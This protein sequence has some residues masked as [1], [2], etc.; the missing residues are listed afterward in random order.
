MSRFPKIG[1]LPIGLL[2][3]WLIGLCMQLLHPADQP[4]YFPPD[5][6]VE[7]YAAGNLNAR[8]QNPY[9][10]EL[11]LPIER[12]A[13]RVTDEAI[14]MW[15]P[16]W[17][18]A[19]AMP[20]G[21]LQPRPAHTSWIISGVLLILFSAILSWRL[22]KGPVD[23]P[24]Y[25]TMLAIT[26]LPSIFV[27]QAGQIGTFLL[28]G[29]VALWYGVQHRQ[30]WI[31]GGGAALLAIKPH[32]V[33][34]LWPALLVWLVTERS[35]FVVLSAIWCI[36][37]LVIATGIALGCNPEVLSQFITEM[38]ERPP[39]QWKSPT[40][41]SW[42]R[43]WAGADL[44]WLQFVPML[45]GIIWWLSTLRTPIQDGYRVLTLILV[46]FVTASYGAWPFDVVMLLPIVIVLAVRSMSYPVFLRVLV[47]VAYLMWLG[48]GLWMNSRGMT[49][50]KFFWMAPSLLLFW[51]VDYL[52]TK[53]RT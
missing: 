38:R 4:P 45:L 11:L 9:S 28:F 18:L 31:V 1:L 27:I 23:K 24:I 33:Y 50:E 48:L 7:Y 16:P 17:T 53:E 36:S 19:I 25:A 52:A 6:F 21:L 34:L 20:V 32:L 26:F 51:I 42:L 39:Q 2:S 3:G 46:S 47:Y 44:F 5:D 41:G 22:A 15:N 30:F 37:F 35:R 29:G 40:L 43:E 13:G 14:M 49:S 8:G 12:A 10:A